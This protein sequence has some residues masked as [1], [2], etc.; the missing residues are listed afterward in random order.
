MDIFKNLPQE[1]IYTIL[2]YAGELRVLQIKMTRENINRLINDDDNVIGFMHSIVDRPIRTRPPIYYI[3]YWKYLSII[4]G[5]N[6]ITN[7]YNLSQETFD[8]L[9]YVLTTDYYLDKLM[10]VVIND[11][12]NYYLDD[13]YYNL[14]WMDG[15][16][17]I[18]YSED[19]EADLKP[20]IEEHRFKVF[21]ETYD[22]IYPQE[23]TNN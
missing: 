19:E 17:F 10:T 6:M 12:N 15:K 2:Q 14:C 9:N 13:Y 5:N 16:C 8:K 1:L 21:N 3:V 22:Y 18:N 20:N 4:Y 11:Y 23:I 7:N